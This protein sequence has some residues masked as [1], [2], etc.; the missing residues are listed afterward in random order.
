MGSAEGRSWD[1]A[2]GSTVAYSRVEL[3]RED[4]GLGAGL[5]VSVDKSQ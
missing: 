3:A 4:R 1:W 5:Q 2:E